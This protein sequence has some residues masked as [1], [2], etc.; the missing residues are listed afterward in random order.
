M[1]ELNRSSFVELVCYSTSPTD[2][3]RRLQLFLRTW[4]RKWL[5]WGQWSMHA[6]LH[7]PNVAHDASS[8]YV[9]WWQKCKS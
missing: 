8:N 5:M 7:S 3:R 1:G 9:S 4:F 2:V 6:D